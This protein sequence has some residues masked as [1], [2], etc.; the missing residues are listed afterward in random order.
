MKRSILTT[1]LV[2]LAAL[3]ALPAFG[4]T[5][6]TVKITNVSANQIVSPPV[7]AVHSPRAR[8][9]TPGEPA[10]DG[11]A[12]LAEDADAAGLLAELDANPFVADVAMGESVLLPGDTV[13]L[14][15]RASAAAPLL[16]AVGMLVTTNDGFFGLDGFPI[17]GGLWRKSTT[18]PAWDAGSEANTESCDHIPGPPCGNP[19]VR[20]TDGAEGAIVVHPGIQGTGDLAAPE[21]DWRNPVVDV[22]VIRRG[23]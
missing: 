5:R 1:V 4:Q 15:V 13:T 6:F 18:A 23:R 19:F 22:V 2:L 10:S 20:V 17:T 16:S 9:F 11:L 14:E 12:A 7:V 21:W 8:L 3:T